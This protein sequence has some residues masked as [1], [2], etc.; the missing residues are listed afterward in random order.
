MDSIIEEIDLNN[1]KIET[2]KID[3]FNC[4][5]Y[6]PMYGI[7]GLISTFSSTLELYPPS[8]QRVK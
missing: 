4:M 6:M 7:P 1:E 8:S 3:G 2:E 5:E